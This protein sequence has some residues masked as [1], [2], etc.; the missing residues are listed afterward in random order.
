MKILFV[1]TQLGVGGAEK[2]TVNLAEEMSN[3]GHTVEIVS[4][5]DIVEIATKIKVIKLNF[6][7]NFFQSFFKL[8]KLIKKFRPDIVHSHCIH[9]NVIVRLMRLTIS[10]DK[11][12]SS[13]HSS[14]EAV[15]L[16]MKIYK[17]TNWLSD[18]NTNVSNQAVQIYYKNGYIKQ[19]NMKVMYN[20]INLDD[21]KFQNFNRISYRKYFNIQEN[22]KIM[23]SVGAFKEAKDY[24]NLIKSIFHLKK[25]YNLNNKLYIAGDGL[26]IDSIKELA[27]NLG[28]ENQVFFLGKRSDISKLMSMADIFVLSSSYEGLPTVLIEAIMGEC[29]IVSTNCEG[30]GEILSDNRLIANVG[31]PSELADKITL[32]VSFSNQEAKEHI[33]NNLDYVVSKFCKEKIINSWLDLYES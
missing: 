6:N 7:K 2:V 23:L 26:L 22:E 32:A 11:L 5:I 12:I 13:A 14:N 21:F 24:P 29:V 25:K 17:Y 33:A 27:I 19:N 8:R 10:F 20:S 30:V 18:Y 1:I 4:L 15:G 28:V 9:A 16:I 3:L 31:S